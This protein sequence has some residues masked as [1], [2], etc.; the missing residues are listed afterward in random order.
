MNGINLD[1]L[2]GSE[3]DIDLLRCPV[4][5]IGILLDL[6]RFDRFL[7]YVYVILLK[8]EADREGRA[9]YRG[10]ARKGVTRPAIVKR[11]LRSREY[12]SSSVEEPG[13]EID[14]FVNRSYQDILGRWPDQEGL[15]TYRRI[16][17]KPNGRRKVLANLRAS[18]EA[19]RKSGGR[20][21]KI[22][23][24]RSYARAGWSARLPGV[25]PLFAA[26][27]KLRQRLDRIA[28][29][30]CLLARQVASLRE[31]LEAASMVGAEPFGFV[32]EPSGDGE[33]RDGGRAAV[34]FQNAL[35]RAR[36]E[37]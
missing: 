18:D 37:A 6:V 24:L 27:G 20:L 2:E 10:L 4:D 34:I 29:N 33:A 31:E 15:T 26:R 5:Q 11:L 16:A 13:L 17:A 28:L 32:A 23:V 36:R 35:I 22:E 9:Y 3:A 14:E 25:G 19:L 7:D 1:I 21:A 8:R 12:K 30:Q